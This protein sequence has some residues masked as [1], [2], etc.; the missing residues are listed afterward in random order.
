VATIFGSPL[1]TFL[2]QTLGWRET[3]LAVSLLSA[4]AFFAIYFWVPQTASLDGVPVVQELSS[5]RKGS[6]WAM[7][8][9]AAI[10]V[11]SIFAVYTFIGPII[12]DVA[13]FG[14]GVIPIALAVFGLGMTAGNIIGGRMADLHPSRGIVAGYGSALAVLL[15]LAIR[16]DSS[17]VLFPALFGVGATM[18]AAIPTIQVR[19]TQ[20][21]PEAPSLMGS[22]NLASLNLA[23]ALGAWAASLA[24]GGGLGILSSAWAGFGLTLVGLGIFLL[25][26]LS[27]SGSTARAA[28]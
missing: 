15:V 18:M 12:T 14:A 11:G 6:V 21:A 19:L 13:G 27:R 10:G 22:M 16:G 7:M 5:L 1:A 4:S 23:N 9:V 3:Y 24:I 26:L 20:L 8:L 2:G 17:W 25:I 28:D